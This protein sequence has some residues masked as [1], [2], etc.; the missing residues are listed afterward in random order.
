M[1]PGFFKDWLDRM[2]VYWTWVVGFTSTIEFQDTHTRACTCT[3]TH[4]HTH[5]HCGFWHSLVVGFSII[6]WHANQP[7]MLPNKPHLFKIQ[8]SIIL[9][10]INNTKIWNL[11]PWFRDKKAVCLSTQLC[12]LS[13]F[14]LFEVHQ[15]TLNNNIGWNSPDFIYKFHFLFCCSFSIEKTATAKVLPWWILP[16]LIICPSI[17]CFSSLFLLI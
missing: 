16:Q 15:I 12:Y 9:I 4:T 2:L 5:T 6:Y 10:Q 13:Y 14:L 1:L 3:H 11:D 7:L 8:Q 17:N